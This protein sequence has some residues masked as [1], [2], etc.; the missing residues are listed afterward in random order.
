[1]PGLKKREVGVEFPLAHRVVEADPLLALDL[2]EL[3]GQLGAEGPIV[4][5]RLPEGLEGLGQALGDELELA[6]PDLL[7][8]ELVEV[9]EVGFS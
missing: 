4:P 7:Q 6:R 9:V 3:L 2:E 5:R 8:R 1:M